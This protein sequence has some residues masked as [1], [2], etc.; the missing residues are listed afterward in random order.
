M[1]VGPVA[2]AVTLGFVLGL[3]HATDPDHL[4]AV[5]TI[6]TRERRFADGAVIGLLW[7]LGHTLTLAVA[8]GLVVALN[9]A[10]RPEV[11][12]GLE[13]VVAAMI[14][15]LGALRLREA[16]RGI[17]AV[18]HGHLLADHEHADEHGCLRDGGAVHSHAHAHAG[19]VHAH[20]HVHP[21]R[22]LLATLS[23]SSGR[24]RALVVGAVHGLAGTA[25]VSL[26]VLTTLTSPIDA[27]A[28]LI[29]FGLGT[30]AGMTVLTAAMAWPLA[31][32]LRFRRAHRALSAVTGVG[33][34]AFG[35]WHAITSL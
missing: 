30:I 16:L 27:A 9:L 25:A 3:Q 6:V 33:S 34:I 24:A 7:G 14:V 29:V 8:G 28:Y 26:L 23:G 5:A 11:S 31:L 32:A 13:Q 35:L 15:L 17:R 10:I 4:V 2:S 18:P 21:S 12:R 22:R 19:G 20:P 1:I